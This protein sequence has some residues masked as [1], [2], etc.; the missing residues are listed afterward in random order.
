VRLRGLGG[1]A[2]HAGGGLGQ[3]RASAL[4]ARGV[5]ANASSRHGLVES[6]APP[7]P[8]LLPWTPR[9]HPKRPPVPPLP[10]AAAA[11]AAAEDLA[12]AWQR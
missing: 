5:R 9:R 3:S 11:V 6:F 4:R 12:G 8:T 7:P 10:R 1:A 2:V